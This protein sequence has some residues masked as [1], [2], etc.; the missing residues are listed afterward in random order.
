MIYYFFFGEDE[1]VTE[2][3]EDIAENDTKIDELEN[4]AQDALQHEQQL[5]NEH[6]VV[7]GKI[8]EKE[9]EIDVKTDE[10]DAK[11]EE[12]ES[13]KDDTDSNLAYINNKYKKKK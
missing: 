4:Q 1:V 7:Q 10:Y 5:A 8:D 6:Q 13:K 3:K 11:I 2:I 12:I 9:E